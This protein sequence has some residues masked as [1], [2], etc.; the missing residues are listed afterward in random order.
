M[1][2]IEERGQAIYDEHLK[3][4]LEPE[5]LG[6]AVAI[7]LPS[8]DYAVHRNWAMAMRQIRRQHPEGE[9]YTLFIGPPTPAE[10][11]LATRLASEH[12]KP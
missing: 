7:H 12:R 3:R 4:V 10:I 8:G 11:A 1:T 9:V 2:T 5:H 6:D